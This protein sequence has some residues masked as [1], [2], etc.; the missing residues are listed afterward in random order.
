MA[1]LAGKIG[2]CLALVT[3]LG[4]ICAMR[5]KQF[6]QIAAVG[7]GGGEERGESAGLGGVDGSAVGEE[8]AD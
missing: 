2:C 3:F 8:E 1:A 7:G 5:K 6:G 4:G